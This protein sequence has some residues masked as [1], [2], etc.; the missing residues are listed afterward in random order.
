MTIKSQLREFRKTLRA[1]AKPL[2]TDDELYV[3]NVHGSDGDDVVRILATDIEDTAGSGLFYF[4]GQRGTGKSTELRRLRTSL[5]AANMR[6]V[7][8]DSLDYLNDSKPIDVEILMLAVAAG[9]ADWAGKEYPDLAANSEGPLT[10]FLNWL[11]TDVEV[12]SIPIPVVGL[13]VRIKAQQ[14]SIANK[15]ATIGDRQRFMASLS[16]HISQMAEAVR[17]RENRN[18]VIVVDSLENLRGNP[19]AADGGGMFAA[20]ARVFGEQMDA[21]SVAGVHMVYSVPP[22]LCLLENVK[23]RVRW[24][25]LASVRVCDVPIGPARRQPRRAGLDALTA[26]MNKRCPQWAQVLTP[27]ALDRMAMLS[28]G[29]LRQFILQLMVEVFTRAEYTSSDDLPLKA[30]SDLL[31]NVAASFTNEMLQL[32]VRNEWPLLK[33]VAE[34]NRAIVGERGQLSVLAHLLDTKVILNY[35]NGVDWYD[36]HPALWDEIDRFQIDRVQ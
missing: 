14:E 15:I 8:F 36:I 23:A 33:T 3:P 17:A 31:T 5:N 6:C 32:T 26:V 34:S 27:A 12:N 4:T 20:V 11:N 16:G 22:Y 29:D 35:R 13:S 28:G 1:N 10:R 19:L 21:L 24:Y 25:A 18:V 30:D 7:L 2:E 9:F